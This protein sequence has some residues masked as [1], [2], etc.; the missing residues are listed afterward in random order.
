MFQSAS[1]IAMIQWILGRAKCLFIRAHFWVTQSVISN[2]TNLLQDFYI[3]FIQ[4]PAL[5]KFH[6]FPLLLLSIAQNLPLSNL[7]V[8]KSL[9][10]NFPPPDYIALS[11]LT[12]PF[13]T[14]KLFLLTVQF[15]FKWSFVLTS[16]HL[17]GFVN[18]NFA[19]WKCRFLT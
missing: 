17:I 18:L 13:H 7:R 1:L 9:Y 12:I 10:I 15:A 16:Y 19:L 8:A 6:V 4:L 11:T 3:F 14:L 2:L 5:L